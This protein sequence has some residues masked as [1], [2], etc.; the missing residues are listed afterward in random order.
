MAKDVFISYSSQ[1]EPQ[2][3][4]A[5]AKLEAK[6]V[7][8]WIAPRDITPGKEWAEAIVDGIARARIMVLVFSKSTNKSQQVRREV[9]L[10]VANNLILIPV[11]LENVSPE[12]SLKFYLS[13]PHWLDAFPTPFTNHLDRLAEVVSSFLP[14][15]DPQSQN[16]PPANT[17]VVSSIAEPST[18]DLQSARAATTT[19]PVTYNLLSVFNSVRISSAIKSAA[20]NRTALWTGG[21]HLVP[22]RSPSEWNQL[23]EPYNKGHR[24]FV[25][26]LPESYAE[27]VWWQGGGWGYEKPRTRQVME[28]YSTNVPTDNL[29]SGAHFLYINDVAQKKIQP[30][31][32]R[33]TSWIRLSA[34][35]FLIAGLSSDDLIFH[36]KALV[37]PFL[38]R[39]ILV[40]RLPAEGQR[41]WSMS[42]TSQLD[43]GATQDKLRDW[44]HSYYK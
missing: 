25:F 19:Q 18:G 44:F 41:E 40:V 13:T 16:P 11:R 42:G 12:Q 2:A 43:G 35:Q 32:D 37:V 24:A 5:C 23:V 27:R 39:W 30:L 3:F 28:R 9:E 20:G 31:L 33:A 1:D 14:L 10:A 7:R 15:T 26:A 8:C 22:G 4:A 36:M 6:G 21:E 17:A 38:H 29:P 34:C